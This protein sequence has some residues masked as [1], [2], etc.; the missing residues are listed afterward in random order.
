MQYVPRG[1]HFSAFILFHTEQFVYVS[2]LQRTI[3]TIVGTFTTLI[4][5]IPMV[6]VLEMLVIVIFKISSIQWEGV[7]KTRI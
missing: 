3:M 1:L 7:T 4:R 2:L 6:I 5:K